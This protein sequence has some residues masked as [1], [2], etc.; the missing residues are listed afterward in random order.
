[1]TVDYL[2]HSQLLVAVAVLSLAVVSRDA[3][4]EPRGH[5][6]VVGGT[7]PFAEAPG[8]RLFSGRGPLARSLLLNFVVGSL[9]H[10]TGRRR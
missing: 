7:Q 3:S 10:G 5:A 1:V 6:P 9:S 4:R 8:N 2:V